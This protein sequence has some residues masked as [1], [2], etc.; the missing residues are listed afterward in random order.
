MKKFLL[1]TLYILVPLLVGW[2][3]I[4]VMYR[5]VPNNYVAKYD[6]LKTH[7]NAEIFILGNSHSFYG[8]Y[9]ELMSKDAYNASN[10]SQGLLCD[11]LIF[12]K[13]IAGKTNA[14]AIV[15]NADYTTF[16]EGR[17][18]SE[19]LW[20]RY[21]YRHFLHLDIPDMKPLDPKLYSLALVT[22]FDLTLENIRLYA[23]TGTFQQC[24]SYG[25]G[26]NEGIDEEIN[27]EETA[28]IIVEKHSESTTLSEENL[29][30]LNEIISL[31]EKN[32][33]KVLI[34][35][36]PVTSYYTALTDKTR[37]KTIKSICKKMENHKNV[38]YLNLFE[39]SRFTNNDFH[40]PDHLNDEGAKKCTA[41]INTEFEK[42]SW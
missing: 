17:E 32:N 8:I 15:L 24:S 12:E 11:K 30:Y 36:M 21:F 19:F 4:E 20:R 9:P 10:I 38:S 2:M 13:Y 37:V 23:N 41:I 22:R 39:D 28:K 35:S 5:F 31:A 40:D 18:N 6:G 14:K 25:N 27:N 29:S 7:K 3:L 1:R 26:K 16:Y 42:N 33:I 34:V